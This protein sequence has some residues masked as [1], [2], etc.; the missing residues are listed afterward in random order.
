MNRAEVFDGARL[1]GK[2]YSLADRLTE[3]FAHV[4]SPGSRRGIRAPR[5]AIL[6]PAHGQTPSYPA[7]EIASEDAAE[8]LAGEV[9]ELAA[10][11]EIAREPAAEVGEQQFLSGRSHLV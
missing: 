3:H 4:R 8:L 7:R 2:E 11:L 1:T 10:L 6:A 5:P 9:L